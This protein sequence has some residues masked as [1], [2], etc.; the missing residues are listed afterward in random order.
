[1][2]LMGHERRTVSGAPPVPRVLLVMP[3]PKLVRA[4]VDA[5][6]GVW[7]V[8]DPKLGPPD[9]PGGPGLPPERLLP[10]DLSDGPALRALL[11]ETARAH[12][13]EQILW[14]VDAPGDD[15]AGSAVATVAATAPEPLPGDRGGP[16]DRLPDAATVRRVL[17]RSGISVVR[18]EQ[19]WTV[20]EAYEAA[21][22]FPLPVVVKWVDATGGS[23]TFPVL[24][25]ADLDRWAAD[26]AT[27]PARGPYLLEELLAG[28]RF[29]VETVT[30]GG[31][32]LVVD[33][34]PGRL[35]ALLS[36]AD[37]AGIRETVRALLDLV[38]YE[39]GTTRTD[40]RLTANGPRVVASKETGPRQRV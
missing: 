25:R 26:A 37:R 30:V 36:E 33:I 31:M 10:A 19:A 23:H 20:A 6:I 35:A 39:A 11:A 9:L 22:R 8:W 24:D 13:I 34:V 32:H 18:A 38:G 16:A 4:A 15:G 3:D 29:L 12:G 7:A 1:M 5:G 40:V 14:P 2:K 28:P 17:N 27:A 21:G